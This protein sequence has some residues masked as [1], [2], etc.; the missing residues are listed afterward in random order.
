MRLYELTGEVMQLQELLED[1]VD[2]QCLA[3]TLEAVQG[4][5]E[6]KLE[7]YCKI[8][9]NLKAD[10][11]ALTAEKERLDNKCTLIKNNIERLK[12]AMYDS[13]KATN[14][15]KVKGNLFTVSIQKNGGVIPVVYDKTNKAITNDLADEYVIVS[16]KPNIDVIR[17][18]LEE[19]KTVKGFT[20]GERGDSLRIK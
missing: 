4:E 7:A 12:K 3:D 17:A 16:E 15:A 9:Y 10:V 2:D 1:N 20:L 11:D 5:Y 13:M 19:G 6:I 18:A 8:I 14:T